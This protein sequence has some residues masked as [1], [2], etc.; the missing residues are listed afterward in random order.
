[1][2]VFMCS[3]RYIKKNENQKLPTSGLFS[4][5]ATYIYIY[6]YIYNKLTF[7]PK[8]T[9]RIKFGSKIHNDEHVSMNGFTVQ[10]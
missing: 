5:D 2:F 7:N 4:K 10:W 1:M 6:I 8:K 3:I 9:V